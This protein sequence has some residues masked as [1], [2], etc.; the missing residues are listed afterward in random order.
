M[1][2]SPKQ[3]VTELCWL[4]ICLGLTLLLSLLFLGKDIF[5]STVDIHLHDTYFV[6]EPLHILL[7][8]FLLVSFVFYFTREFRQSFRRSLPN[9]ILLITGLALV[10]T[11]TFLVKIFSGFTTTGW[12]AYPPLS[13]PEQQII[14]Q[15]TQEP[16]VS[17]LVN[18]FT[19][20]QAVVV[21]QLL[22]V[23]FRWGY[24]YRS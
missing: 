9:C 23:T 13:A 14:P 11:I 22:F 20:I 1:K 18:V 7:P 24:H 17:V 8:F 21:L 3:M 19:V 10:I 6:I 16:I 12:T 2:I 5:K 4:V 15:V